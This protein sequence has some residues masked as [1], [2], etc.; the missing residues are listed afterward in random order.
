MQS[1]AQHICIIRFMKTPEAMKKL[2]SLL[3]IA[4]TFA[5]CDGLIP[6]DEILDLDIPE[7]KLSYDDPTESQKVSFNAM[8]AWEVSVADKTRAS[9]WLSIDPMEG[10]AG[11]AT[12]TL[13]LTS[14][15]MG[16]E[17]R[18]ATVTVKVGT[19]SKS[20][21]VTQ[22]SQSSQNPDGPK[23]DPDKFVAAPQ[24]VVYSFAAKNESMAV[25]SNF[26][27]IMDLSYN[28]SDRGWLSYSTDRSGYDYVITF[29]VDVNNSS[30]ERVAVMQFK[31]DNGAVYAVTYITQTAASGGTAGLKVTSET[32]V[33][34]KAPGGMYP[35]KATSGSDIV[36][37]RQ[38]EESADWY[39]VVEADLSNPSGSD[40][41][42]GYFIN[43]YMVV[44][45]NYTG[46]DR[47]AV[48]FVES[49][50]EPK[51]KIVVDQL[52][53]T[54]DDY[55]TDND[56]IKVLGPANMRFSHD[57]QEIVVTVKSSLSA[58]GFQQGIV[59]P[60]WCQYAGKM[61]ETMFGNDI[62]KWNLT[63]NTGANPN[64]LSFSFQYTTGS[65]TVA[66]VPV[67]FTQDVA[68]GA[69][70]DPELFVY[71]GDNPMVFPVKGGTQEAVVKTSG[72]GVAVTCR[73]NDPWLNV[74]C[75]K[76]SNGSF[77]TVKVTVPS[78]DDGSTLKGSFVVE[79]S[80][81]DGTAK[82]VHVGV[83]VG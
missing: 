28:G 10:P 32:S 73:S 42:G 75:T 8:E 36:V 33:T 16:Q 62:H 44:D 81:T 3:F 11:K 55:M 31:D 18:S 71:E 1:A 52:K 69:A 40:G 5:A 41:K 51:V 78:S 24:A 35:L 2:L 43:K 50:T 46:A 19:V 27:M 77:Y 66:S 83:T 34:A 56:H 74:T 48:F 29:N 67:S 6:K 65:G 68:G 64:F 49:G 23:P 79:S 26:Q 39:R 57:S 12:L 14:A 15:N 20:F 37:Y 58:Y 38:D 47:Q 72:P 17:P 70:P 13:S 76:G 80:T 4:G 9:S 63:K 60:E 59:W 25:K 7:V 21:T 45:C 53:S 30:S 61:T 82:T 22:H 54:A